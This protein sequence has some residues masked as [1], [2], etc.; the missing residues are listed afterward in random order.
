[1]TTTKVEA[2]DFNVETKFITTETDTE[3]LTTE[4]EAEV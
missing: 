4:A 1:L 2:E 3:V